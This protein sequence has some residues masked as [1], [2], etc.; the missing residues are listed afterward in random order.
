MTQLARNLRQIQRDLE[1]AFMARRKA[2]IVYAVPKGSPCESCLV[3]IGSASCRARCDYWKELQR[4]KKSGQLERI[5]E[6]TKYNDR[7]R[8][9]DD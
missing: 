4:L 1:T 9:N 6:V 5:T 2:R 8:R 7:E 3:K